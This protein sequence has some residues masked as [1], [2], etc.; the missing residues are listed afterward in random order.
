MRL[1][2][3]IPHERF[4]IQLHA[5]NGKYILSISI[6]QYEQSFKVNESDFSHMDQLE[7]LIEGKFLS[8]CIHRFVEMRNDWTNLLN[9]THE[10]EH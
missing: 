2:K 9:N 5:Y 4:F 10:H 6:D 7:K 3:Q 1:I 8:N